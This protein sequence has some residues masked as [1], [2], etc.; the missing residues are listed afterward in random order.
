MEH[1]I[2]SPQLTPSMPLLILIFLLCTPERGLAFSFD[3]HEILDPQQDPILTEVVVVRDLRPVSLVSSEDLRVTGRFRDLGQMYLTAGPD[4]KLLIWSGIAPYTG[5][6]PDLLN[7]REAISFC[8][9][10]GSRSRLPSL[11]DYRF[12]SRTLGAKEPQTDYAD[13]DRTIIPD[14]GVQTFWTSTDDPW[15]CGYAYYFSGYWGNIRSSDHSFP[16]SV[17]CVTDG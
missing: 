7:Q 6:R 15:N 13:Y 14:V 5:I 2:K 4:G 9:S 8:R 16:R 1:N 3:Y 10:L 11:A 17:R 12:L